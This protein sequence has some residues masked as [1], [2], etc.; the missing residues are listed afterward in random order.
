VLIGE[1]THANSNVQLTSMSFVSTD[2][3]PKCP[4]LHKTIHYLLYLAQKKVF[5]LHLFSRI[6]FKAFDTET[7]HA[8]IVTGS[9]ELSP[10]EQDL[11][12]FCTTPRLLIGYL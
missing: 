5:Y 2:V 3:R 8:T 7:F 1:A 9:C 4:K 11:E 10:L 6:Y 12:M